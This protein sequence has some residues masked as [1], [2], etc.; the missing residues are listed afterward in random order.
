MNIWKK[1]KEWINNRR[2]SRVMRRFG[3]EIKITEMEL[4][5]NT[6]TMSAQHPEFVNLTKGLVYMFKT[7]GGTNYVSATVY[8][9]DLGKMEITLQRVNG[10]SVSEINAELKLKI[11]ELE[12]K[13]SQTVA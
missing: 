11:K 3:D 9:I 6:L 2:V 8:D 12:D 10:K 1:F 4:K 13:L 5:N 7:T